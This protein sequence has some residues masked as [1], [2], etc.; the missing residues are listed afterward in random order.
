MVIRSFQALGEI[1][2]S[3]WVRIGGFQMSRLFIGA[4]ENSF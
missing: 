3:N 1:P 4:S 2:K